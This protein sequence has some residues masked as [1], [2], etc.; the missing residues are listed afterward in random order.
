MF[1][2]KCKYHQTIQK[3]NWKNQHHQ[4]K[5]AAEKS[6]TVCTSFIA[7][8]NHNMSIHPYTLASPRFLIADIITDSGNYIVDDRWSYWSDKNQINF[9]LTN[10]QAHLQPFADSIDIQVK[11]YH[12]RFS[13]FSPPT[14][15]K[16]IWKKYLS[17]N[18]LS[19]HEKSSV[20]KL[21]STGK[22]KK[23]IL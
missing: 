17:N 7:S 10:I 9:T 6:Q 12:R 8:R 14:P 15:V 13:H 2:V 3:K 5:N 11:K 16:K 20:K 19:E 21:K 23:Y 22:A 1:A 4:E 18:N